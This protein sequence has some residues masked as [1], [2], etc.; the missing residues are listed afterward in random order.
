MDGYCNST[1]NTSNART[2]NGQ[3]NGYVA[4]SRYI[5][6]TTDRHGG[7]SGWPGLGWGLTCLLELNER[8]AMNIV[9][10]MSPRTMSIMDNGNCSIFPLKGSLALP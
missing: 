3:L 10:T 5:P 7:S 8:P 2:G 4:S 1:A 9:E 6:T